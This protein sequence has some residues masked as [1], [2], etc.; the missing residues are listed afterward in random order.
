MSI[1]H[2]LSVNEVI[3][4]HFNGDQKRSKQLYLSNN[5]SATGG[6]EVKKILYMPMVH[7]SYST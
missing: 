4:L 3:T 1:N 7:L 6:A 2:L 5:P